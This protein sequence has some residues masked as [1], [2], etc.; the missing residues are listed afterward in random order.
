MVTREALDRV[1]G[2]AMAAGAA[3]MKHYGQVGRVERKADES[4]LTAADKDAHHVIVDALRAWHPDIPVISEEGAIPPYERRQGWQRFWLVD[5][6]DG[7]REFLKKNDE[8]T[9]NIA[10]I[11][12]HEPVLGVVYAPALKRLYFAGRGLGSWRRDGDGADQRL[13]GPPPVGD[14]GLIVVESRSH[15]SAEL[16]EWLA[17]R[18]VKSRVQA[19][20]S[21]KFGLVAEGSAHVYPRLGPT[22]EWDVAAGDC[23]WRDAIARGRRPSPLTYN[24]PTLLN[25]GFVIG[26]TS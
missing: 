1:C 11:E 15:P 6:L 16:D 25:A 24:T 13:L 23:V 7:T 19:G 10:L 9:A 14:D 21:L 20:S 18:R 3:S 26:V 17:G 22:S 5:P 8:F 12:G 4:P 2:I